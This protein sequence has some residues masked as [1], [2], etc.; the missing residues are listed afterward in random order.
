MLKSLF[1]ST[2]VALSL[3]SPVQASSPVPEMRPPT[4]LTVDPGGSI[5]ERMR[6]IEL[7]RENN[8]KVVIEGLCI[9][10][11]TMLLSLPNACMKPYTIFG[12]HSASQ[13]FEMSSFG[14]AILKRF[15]PP[16]ILDWVMEKKAL[17]SL[18]LTP[19][20]DVEANSL[21]VPYCAE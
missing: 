19:M 15:Y 10:A 3:L 16:K 12:F 11:C 7:L 20:D 21:G 8:A 9:S 4:S 18:D 13:G 14:N 1:V 5:T 6:T 2:L 17:E